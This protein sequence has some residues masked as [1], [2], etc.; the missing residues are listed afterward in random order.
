MKTNKVYII[1]AGPIGLVTAWKLLERGVNVEIFEKNSLVGGMCRT[2][3][4]NGFLLDTGPHIFH[5]PHKSLS[6]F[7][8]KEFKGLF[9]KK[10]FWCKNVKKENPKIYWDYPVSLESINKYP[11]ELKNKIKKEL[12]EIDPN[13]KLKSSSYFDYMK[14]EVGPTLA[15]MFFTKYPEKIWGIN[16]KKITPEWA[17]K[18]VE[19][20]KK[21]TPFYYQQWNAVAKRGT[22]TIY[23]NIKTKILKL[24]G[25]IHLNHNL[26]NINY[27]GTSVE[28]LKFKNKKIKIYPDDTIV[29][30]LPITMT[31]R[32]FN[33][34]TN[35]KFRG[36]RTIYLAFKKKKILPKNIHWLYFGDK[37][38]IFNRLT[39]PKKMT[40]YVSPKNYTYL[41]AE[42]TYSLGD[43][44]DKLSD[45]E[46][47]DITLKDLLKIN[48][49]NKNEF[50]FGSS[51]KEPFVYPLMFKGYQSELSS[52]KSNLLKFDQLYS[53]GTGGDFNYA[54][55]QI[56]F[57]KAFDLAEIISKKDTKSIN[58]KRDKSF[59]RFNKNIEYKNI[60]IG[61]K[62]KPFVIAEAGI[63]HNG[64]LEIAK[65]LIDQSKFAGCD[66]VK[67][68]S[69]LKDTRIS[70]KVKSSNYA[71]Q[72]NDEQ[73]NLHQMFER[74]SLS[75]EKQ[76][77][78]F[79]YARKKKV[80]IFSTPFD[81]ESV[82]F[83]ESQKV[84]LYKIASMDL[85]NLPLI[86]YVAK[87]NK[88][89]IL[90]TGM[91]TLAQIE[92][93]V[94][95]IRDIGN[96]NLS[97][98]HCNST[99]PSPVESMNLR[100][101][102]SLKLSFG[103]TT[104]ISDHTVGP[105]IP[106]LATIIGANVIEKHFTINKSYDGPDHVLSAD[107]EEMKK[108]CNFTNKFKAI[109]NKELILNNLI[110]KY[111]LEK[112]INKKLTKNNLEMILGDGIK[113][114]LPSEYETINSQRK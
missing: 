4:W 103:T 71:E 58:I 24:G 14:N 107:F 20:R 56:L 47:I 67:F 61:E 26:E 9:V 6:K 54:D 89:I 19:L 87:K 111:N 5:T 52:V 22:G 23:E 85:V 35:L 72:V 27:K 94:S 46:I 57:H 60:K 43:K 38:T 3:K 2:W 95:L 59:F 8:E 96:P 97:L 15:D 13:T 18:R 100:V 39:E 83:L 68:Q 92:D 55:S 76:E 65:K 84:K 88:P 7:W 112:I 81:K 105:L 40:K 45:K 34:K 12:K 30:S 93:A 41:S 102:N 108:I 113:R 31:A 25:K 86:E 62:F 48:L 110:K 63:N 32:F 42:I 70:A 109:K 80:E 73:E 51:N 36:I 10:N 69:F 50:L 1:G 91:S 99:Y 106:L 11:K 82:D 79:N 17:P 28:S 16:T 78:L 114:I 101:M 44:I 21:N 29:S 53:V 77:E 66:V 90:S 104:G 74:L 49:V 37:H 33:I 75:F 98:L 64:S